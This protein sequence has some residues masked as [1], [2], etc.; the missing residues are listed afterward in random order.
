MSGDSLSTISLN[1]STTIGL[2]EVFHVKGK[3]SP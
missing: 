3:C 1:P 2:C